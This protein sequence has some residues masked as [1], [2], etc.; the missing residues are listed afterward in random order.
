M[1]INSNEGKKLTAQMVKDYALENGADLAGIAS[2]SRF[3]DAPKETHPHSVM[4]SCKS[5][6]VIS[7]RILEGS[8]MGNTRGVD[9]STYWIYGYGTGLYGPMVE[10]TRRTMRYMESFGYDTLESPGASTLLDLPP[11]HYTRPPVK[12]GKLPS[13]TV[14]HM[15]LTAAAAGLGELGWGKVFLTPEFGPRQRFA[16]ILTD[17]ELEPDP[18]MKENVCTRCMKCVDACPGKALSKTKKVSVTIE[19]R[20]FEW[21]DIHVGKCKLTHW[22]LNKEASPFIN[23]DIPGF[24]YKIEDQDINWYDAFRLGF[25]MSQRIRYNKTLGLDGFPEI[26]QGTR[27][28][29]ICGAYGCIQACY[30]VLNGGKKLKGHKCESCDKTKST[31]GKPV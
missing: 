14:L 25:A 2:I 9:Y 22:G 19:D 24:N 8:Y 5:V 29:S 4:P 31:G 6:V 11:E 16:L 26:E 21:G 1:F 23:R 27:P 30:K 13:N 3:K 10:S 17:A 20:T 18:L 15:R 7:C 12:P 28:G